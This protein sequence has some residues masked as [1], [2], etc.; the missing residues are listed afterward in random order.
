MFEPGEIANPN[1]RSG[2]DSTTQKLR[3]ALELAARSRKTTI[4]KGLADL[5]FTDDKWKLA[6][7]P[8]IVP[9]LRALE[10]SGEVT[11]PFKFVIESA[12]GK[13]VPL[14]EP[15]V[16]KQIDSKVVVATIKHDKCRVASTSTHS[17]QVKTKTH[18]R[19]AKPK[20]SERMRTAADE[21]AQP[22][23]QARLDTLLAA[24]TKSKQPKRKPAATS[25]K[26]CK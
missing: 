15:Q 22:L 7:L 2:K 13:P 11:V 26:G 25:H 20:Q 18:K 12:D 24:K 9:R 3:K 5:F 1:G 23:S 16:V 17:G 19:K 6:L 4:Y 21:L 14:P 10:V 8:Y